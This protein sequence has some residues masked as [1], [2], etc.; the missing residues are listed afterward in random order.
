M[1]VAQS[2]LV[3]QPPRLLAQPQRLEQ[4]L[5]VQQ[6]WLLAR[7]QQA[8]QCCKAAHCWRLQAAGLF[9]LVS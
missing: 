4:L 1:R 6:K 9:G 8:R 3:V 7:L 2:M 5:Q